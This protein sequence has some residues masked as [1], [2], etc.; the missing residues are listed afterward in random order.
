MIEEENVNISIR[1]V[2][3]NDFGDI[4]SLSDKRYGTGYITLK[5]LI[6]LIENG[7]YVKVAYMNNQFAG[8]AIFGVYS[9]TET[10]FKMG[11]SL[12]KYN[13]ITKGKKS[14]VYKSAALYSNFEGNGIMHKLLEQLIY[15]VKQNQFKVVFAAAWIMDDIIPIK[16]TL[17]RF[18][19]TYL[20][21]KKLLWYNDVEYNC[22]C[23][24]GRCACDAA[25][26]YKVL[27]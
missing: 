27:R 12:A 17:Q 18:D 3:C 5:S 16:P 23:C 19:F 20:E 14:I 2:S 10:A 6:K 11:I 7:S 9:E 1:N 8:F 22:I 26:Y 24:K 21:R 4:I 13:E 15:E 25:I